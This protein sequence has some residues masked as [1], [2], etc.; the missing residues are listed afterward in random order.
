MFDLERAH[1]LCEDLSLARA[2]PRV[3]RDQ[4][5][6]ELYG[7]AKSAPDLFPSWQDRDLAFV[8]PPGWRPMNH[9]VAAIGDKLLTV[10]RCTNYII[11]DRGPRP[12]EGTPNFSRTFLLRVDPDDLSGR[13]I[14]ELC[15]SEPYERVSQS[16]PS[17]FED[18]RIF[19]HADELWGIM[20]RCDLN[21]E[22]WPEQWVGKIVGDGFTNLRKLRSP[23]IR[24]PE[25]NWIPFS[26]S[27]RIHF[28]YT[29]D[30]TVILDA[31][32]K[33][34]IEAVPRIH[35]DHFRGSSQ[36]VGFDEGMLAVV[37]TCTIKD[38]WPKNL[39]RFV[40]FN[41]ELRLCKIT[42]AFRFPDR[43]E[44]EFLRGYQYA[45]GLCWHPDQKRLLLSYSL[46]DGQSRMGVLDADDVSAQLREV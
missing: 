13:A 2:I 31:A 7:L 4:A 6:A 8:A 45:M 38:N 27:G 41:C 42:S 33:K 22:G 17:G 35:C 20:C 29:S 40:W 11:D 36:G 18:M 21:E 34:V 32:G 37:H 5:R 23:D 15:L 19:P 12:I 46:G 30:P 24:R 28:V 16:A 3:L 9:S 25:K 43:F 1:Q 26:A 39:I 10:V 44:Q 14:T